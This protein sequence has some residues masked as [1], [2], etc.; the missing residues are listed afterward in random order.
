MTECGEGTLS[1]ATCGILGCPQSQQLCPKINIYMKLTTTARTRTTTVVQYDR[2][3]QTVE[4]TRGNTHATVGT[5]ACHPQKFNSNHTRYVN[6]STPSE[7]QPALVGD[8]LLHIRVGKISLASIIAMARVLSIQHARA[9]QS[10]DYFCC[11]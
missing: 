9:T 11:K 8:I 2:P 7:P 10:W 4:S 6:T 5:R 1:P 3:R